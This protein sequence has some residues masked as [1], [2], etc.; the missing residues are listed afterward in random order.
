MLEQYP[1]EVITHVCDPRTGIQRHCKFPPSISEVVEACD[2]EA[3]MVERRKR[4]MREPLPRAPERLLKDRPQGYLAGIFVPDT[5]AR[6]PKLVEWAGTAE[7]AF[8]KYGNASDGRP[9]IWVNI[10]VWENSR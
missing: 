9:G 6:Y 3:I 1:D 5:H 10:G 4:P 7:M 2:D 8:W